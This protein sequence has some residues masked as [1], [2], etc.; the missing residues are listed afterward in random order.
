MV[1]GT[2]TGVI[3]LIGFTP[4]IFIPTLGGMILDAS[5]GAE[6]YQ[7]FYTLITVLSAV[8]LAAAYV[9]YRK[10]QRATVQA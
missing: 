9:V 2:A 6:G 10:I 1:T 3:S 5:P 8:G 7:N 4:E